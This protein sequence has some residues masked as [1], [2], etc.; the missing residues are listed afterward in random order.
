MSSSQGTG[1]YTEA[2]RA[3]WKDA[4]PKN[5]IDGEWADSEERAA[6]VDPSQHMPTRLH[7]RLPEMKL[8][9]LWRRQPLHSPLG[10]S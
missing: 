3:F 6:T 1:P 9:V 10:R 7:L 4:L 2:L 8:T 5:F